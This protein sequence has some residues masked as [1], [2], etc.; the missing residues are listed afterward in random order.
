MEPLLKVLKRTDVQ[1][2]A[3]AVIAGAQ[4]SHVLTSVTY[5]IAQLIRMLAVDSGFVGFRV[6][7]AVKAVV[8]T[9]IAEVVLGVAVATAAVWLLSRVLARTEP[10][11]EAATED[12]PTNP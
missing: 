11:A 7:T 2:V 12:T 6:A 8:V 4:V 1:I 5:N 3:L 9:T 10:V